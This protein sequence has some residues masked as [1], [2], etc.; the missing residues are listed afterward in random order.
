MN[1]SFLLL[2]ALMV[3]SCSNHEHDAK[4]GHAGSAEPVGGNLAITHFA[5]ATELFVEFP[6]LVKGDE[7]AFAAHVTRLSDFSALT[8]GHV[9]VQL[10]GAGHPEE[11]ARVAVSANPGIF[12]PVL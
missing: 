8:Q 7:A 6:K 9:T 3:S 2:L 1:K 4:G 5:R 10:S 12:R 11:A